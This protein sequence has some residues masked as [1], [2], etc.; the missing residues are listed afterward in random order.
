MVGDSLGP[1]RKEADKPKKKRGQLYFPTMWVVTNKEKKWKRSEN[2]KRKFETTKKKRLGA[3]RSSK[4]STTKLSTLFSRSVLCLCLSAVRDVAHKKGWYWIMKKWVDW[5][6]VFNGRDGRFHRV[7][8]QCNH[9]CSH[10]LNR[11]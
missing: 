6:F 2:K 11:Q 3:A 1:D 7:G 4:I 9:P 8:W 10:Q 5:I